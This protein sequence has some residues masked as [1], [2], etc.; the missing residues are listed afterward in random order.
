MTDKIENDDLSFFVLLPPEIQVEI[1]GYLPVPDLFSVSSSSRHLYS[2]AKNKT[3]WTQLTLDWAHIKKNYKFC[4]DLV[5]SERYSNLKSAL[6]TCKDRSESFVD[7]EYESGKKLA[8]M[9]DMILDIETLTSIKVDKNIFIAEFLLSKISQKASLTKVDVSGYR[10]K[11]STFSAFGN[12]TNLRTLKLF[13]MHNLNSPKS[14]DFEHLFSTLKNLTTVEVP[15]ARITDNAIACL[16]TNNVKL[17][18]L[19]IDN[20]NSVTSK[21]IR[22]LAKACPDLQ[23]VS[24][25]KCDKFRQA[26]ALHLISSC[27]QLRHVGFSRIG[28]KT[29]RKILE[30][31][32]KMR[33]VS[34]YYCQ[35][36]SE[37]GLTEL[38]TSAPRF[39]KL[40][41][42][43]D[44]ILRVSN[45]FDEKFKIKYPDSKVNIQ[46]RDAFK[47]DF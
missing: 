41:L 2:L 16:V 31:C 3:L 46:I 40:E 14:E 13:F 43:K 45:E 21:G 27:P 1:L 33:S 24:M 44:T 20:C 22:I 9:I 47:N 36:V 5:Q 17:T 30:V 19:V 32:P 18:H 6:F 26:D 42:I 8:N 23:H 10:M 7:T 37:G 25:K 29:L 34:L 28:D 39:Q 12:L 11:S 35:L 15:C 38:L 4:K